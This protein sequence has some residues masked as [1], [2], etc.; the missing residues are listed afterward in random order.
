LGDTIVAAED[1]MELPAPG[2][3]GGAWGRS[4][5]RERVPVF[6]LV[7]VYVCGTGMS[8]R[9]ERRESEHARERQKEG[10]SRVQRRV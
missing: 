6:G 2:R 10:A 1:P 9:E 4:G 8:E 7:Y 5:E 3:A